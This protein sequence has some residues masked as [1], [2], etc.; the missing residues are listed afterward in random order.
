M[1]KANE[2]PVSD[3][4]VPSP[5]VSICAL[6]DNDTCIGCFRTGEE[7]S[8]WGGMTTEEKGQ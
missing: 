8:R 5:C 2:P 7:I 1:N 3:N 6:D 4:Q